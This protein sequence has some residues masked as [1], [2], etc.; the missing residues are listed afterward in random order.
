MPRIRSIHPGQWTDAAF[1][2]MSPLARLLALAIRNEADD[3]GVFPWK[4]LD[5]K[6]RL[7][8]GD[9]VK[10]DTLLAELEDADQVMRYELDGREYGAI[11]NFAAFQSP[12][13]PNY[14]HP[15]TDEVLHYVR[16]KRGECG[17]S[18][19]PVRNRYGKSS[20]E[21]VGGEKE[22]S[23]EGAMVRLSAMSEVRR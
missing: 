4:P 7:M 19:V 23:Q 22:P 6:I 3:Q 10:I 2:S 15:V 21:G 13:K 1:L 8:P 16:L 14:V 18:T 17:T 5:L 20:A 11:R 9:N 12:R